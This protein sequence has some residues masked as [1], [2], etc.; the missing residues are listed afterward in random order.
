MVKWTR[1]CLFGI[2][3]MAFKAPTPNWDAT[4]DWPHILYLGTE[5]LD[6]DLFLART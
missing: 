1:E 4:P 3:I 2:N 6:D 5:F